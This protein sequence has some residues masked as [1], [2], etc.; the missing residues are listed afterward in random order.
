[1]KYI[2]I[3]INGKEENRYETNSRNS[4]KHLRE[5]GGHQAI[6]TNKS[7]RVVSAAARDENWNPVL[8]DWNR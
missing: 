1:M 3:I 7:G 5:H 2:V 4:V 6:V 8:I